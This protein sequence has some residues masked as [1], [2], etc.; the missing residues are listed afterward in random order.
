MRKRYLRLLTMFLTTC[1]VLFS[2][3][4]AVS[5]QDAGTTP[6]STSGDSTTGGTTNPDQRG[7]TDKT[8]S[9][10]PTTPGTSSPI[11]VTPMRSQGRAF[12]IARAI[13]FANS[14]SER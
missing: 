8:P 4:L 10:T 9:T 1:T 3:P 13:F 7:G 14:C 5:A 12:F 6:P 11:T 2:V